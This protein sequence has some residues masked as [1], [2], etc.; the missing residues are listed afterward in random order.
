MNVVRGFSE[1]SGF[2]FEQYGFASAL[3]KQVKGPKRI[4]KASLLPVSL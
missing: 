1:V 2:A 4:D 3:L